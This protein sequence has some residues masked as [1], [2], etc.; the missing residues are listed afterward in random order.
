MKTLTLLWQ[1][2]VSHDLIAAY[3]LAVMIDKLPPAT[4]A[5]GGFYR[6]FFGVVQLLAANWERGKRGIQGTL[7][8]PPK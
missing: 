3:I 4:A 5:S 8:E 1:L 2:I 7:G 6:W